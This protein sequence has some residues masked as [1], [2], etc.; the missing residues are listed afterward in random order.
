MFLIAWPSAA[1]AHAILLRTEPAAQTTAAAAP[2][3]VRLFFSEAVELAFGAVRVYDVHGNRVDTGSIRREQGDR[4]V[5]AG[6]RPLQQGT[7]TV[8]WRVV[9]ADAH[10]VQGGFVFDVIAPSAV[11]PQQP[12]AEAGPGAAVGWGFGLVR[13]AWFAAFLALVGLVA[14]RRWVWTPAVQA[15]GLS[16]SSAALGFRRRFRRV[17]PWAWA[18][19]LASGALSLIFEA[20]D[21]SGLSLVSSASPAVLRQIL[22]TSFGHLWAASMA[23]TLLAAVPVLALAGERT[24]WGLAPKRWIVVL[25]ALAVALAVVSAL[26][27]HARTQAD[28]VM[29]VPS[30]AVHLLAVAVWVGGLAALIALAGPAWRLIPPGDRGPF[31]RQLIG[32]FGRLAVAAVL[33]I[34][35]TGVVNAFTD[36]ASVSDLWQTSYGQL[37]TAKVVLLAAALALAAR[38]RYALPPKLTDA[39]TAQATTRSFGRTGAAEVAVL[40]VVVA[41]ASALVA[42]VP[43]RSLGLG[44]QGSGARGSEPLIQT[45]SAGAYTVQAFAD[46][47]TLGTNEIHLTFFDA[48]G[49]G[50]GNIQNAAA[51]LARG[52][53]AAKSVPVRLLAPGHFV[54]DVS[55]EAP[56]EYALAVTTKRGPPAISVT[57][58]FQISR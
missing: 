33:V 26:N 48:R 43:G 31:V 37:V 57:F 3:A 49:L 45:R 22:G 53:S 55:F 39:S 18:L 58:R 10:P 32:R 41:L 4:E 35:A 52:G 21:A 38:H 24:V 2:A 56:G 8:T 11:S 13:F 19:L 5:V 20:A 25:G 36:L 54:A 14:V 15:V 27:G 12:P 6:L 51:A 44:L 17:L 29:A 34:I 50:A 23:L 7:Y 28:P 47:G 46:P 30:L 1:F 42:L 9:S 40:V 16:Q